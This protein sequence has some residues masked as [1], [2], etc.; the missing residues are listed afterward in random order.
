[1]RIRTQVWSPNILGRI[2]FDWFFCAMDEDGNVSTLKNYVELAESTFFETEGIVRRREDN[3]ALDEVFLLSMTEAKRYCRTINSFFYDGTG[4][5]I[6]GYPK[7]SILAVTNGQDRSGLVSILTLSEAFPDR[8]F[9]KPMKPADVFLMLSMDNT[10]EPDKE[11]KMETSKYTAETFERI[12]HKD[13]WYIQVNND[14]DA[15]DVVDLVEVSYHEADG[16]HMSGFVM[17]PELA[18]M[19]GNLLI[20][21]S[22]NLTNK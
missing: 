20:K 18:S 1:M 22:E 21:F 4:Y 14:P 9:D 12:Y 2:G 11:T 19:L 10:V 17:E 3:K 15:I 16:K 8:E 13:G 7:E 5:T 6:V